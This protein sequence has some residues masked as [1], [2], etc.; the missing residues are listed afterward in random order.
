MQYVPVSSRVMAR[1][2][3]ERVTWRA[4]RR[5]GLSPRVL[6]PLLGKHR[7]APAQR[8][9]LDL[10]RQDNRASGSPFRATEIW[11]GVS[12]LFEDWF[13]WEGIA[14]VQT[15]RMSQLFSGVSRHEPKLLAYA[16]WL[17]YQH[18]KARDSFDLLS[19]IP[20]TVSAESGLAFEFEGR[21][22]SWE[23]LISL[24]TLYAIA[25][26][27]DRVLTGP[28]VVVDL[29]AGWGRMGYALLAANPRATYIV[30]DL[31]EALLVSSTYLPRLLNVPVQ[32]YAQTRG[33]THIDGRE[34]AGQALFCGAQDLEKLVDKS[35]DCLINIGSFQEMTRPQVDEYF[36]VLDRK[37]KG[38]FYTLQLWTADTHHLQLG[39]ISGYGAYPFRPQWRQR[40]LRNVSWSN[41]F[42]E[43]V[44]SIE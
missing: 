5:I 34:F 36:S 13:A 2:I 15:Q 41:L 3:A 28:A 11:D 12:R 19:R 39:E 29:G 44:Y 38:L 30:C 21:R 18:I 17:L 14:D 24:D 20:A 23:L 10:M 43:T 31:P 16:C 42:F 33:M 8:A 22:V 37:V 9:I 35:V 25:E 40:Y 6:A 7:L 4:L 32:A 1:Q 27:D 26:V